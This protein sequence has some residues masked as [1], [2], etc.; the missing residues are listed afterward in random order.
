MKVLKYYIY[1][2]TSLRVEITTFFPCPS[3][4]LHSHYSHRIFFFF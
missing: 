1:I 3:A 2:I 4:P